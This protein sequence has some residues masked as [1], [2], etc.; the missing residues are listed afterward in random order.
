MLSQR[1]HG[2]ARRDH[3]HPVAVLEHQ[4]GVGEQDGIAAADFDDLGLDVV[5]EHDAADRHAGQR[6][7]RDEESRDVQCAA[8][9]RDTP[10]FDA[11]ELL[12]RPG[13][14]PGLAEQQQ[15]V[16]GVEPNLR[17]GQLVRPSLSNGH[18]VHARRQAG[19]QFGDRRARLLACQHDLD[20]GG[21]RRRRRPGGPGRGARR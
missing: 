14:A 10:G 17:I 5:G 3:G 15:A 2:L 19:D 18:D 12:L 4:T 6:G 9:A 13:R 8:I 11:A 16:A 20:G 1:W 7:S 21:R